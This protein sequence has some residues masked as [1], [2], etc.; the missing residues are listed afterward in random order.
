MG[1]F[2][3]LCAFAYTVSDELRQ[4]ACMVNLGRMSRVLGSALAVLLL[5]VNCMQGAKCS[6][7]TEALF[8][9]RSESVFE[10]VVGELVCMGSR[11]DSEF[12]C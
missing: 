7:K 11:S 10:L 12:L 4:I 1:S 3:L 5:N 8:F 6:Q 9:I 2:S